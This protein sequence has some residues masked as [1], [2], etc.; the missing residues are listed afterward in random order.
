MGQL[1]QWLP[2]LDFPC[3]L[4]L[5]MDLTLKKTTARRIRITMI[6]PIFALSQ[7][8]P[9]PPV[10][11]LLCVDC[12]QVRRIKSRLTCPVFIISCKSIDS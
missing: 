1:P 11:L 8:I 4:S 12:R 5:M 9:L 10:Y 7:L 3:L 2:Q 6:F